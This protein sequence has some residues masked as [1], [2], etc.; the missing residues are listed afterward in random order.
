[1]RVARG[2]GVALKEL[3]R[4]AEAEDALRRAAAGHARVF[5]ELRWGAPLAN[6]SAV[7]TLLGVGQE[8]PRGASMILRHQV[9]S[10]NGVSASNVR[11]NA[12]G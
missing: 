2:C 3:G 12:S 8:L 9:Y 4:R 6:G 5:A 11:T 7:V 1:M 10:L